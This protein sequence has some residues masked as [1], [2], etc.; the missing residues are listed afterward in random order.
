[1]A[2]GAHA[3]SIEGA[4]LGDRGLQAEPLVDHQRIG[5]EAAVEIVDRCLPLR[6]LM[7][8]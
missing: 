1:M 3:H 5:L 8:R 6:D 4:G 2:R 7:Q